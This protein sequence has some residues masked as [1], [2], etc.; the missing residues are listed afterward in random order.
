MQLCPLPRMREHRDP[1]SPGLQDQQMAVRAF[2]LWQEKHVSS[3]HE[4]HAVLQAFQNVDTGVTAQGVT[5]GLRRVAEHDPCP[6]PG[7]VT[8][9]VQED[10][11][12]QQ[13]GANVQQQ[14]LANRKP[15]RSPRVLNTVC[16]KLQAPWQPRWDHAD[17]RALS[18]GDVFHLC[19]RPRHDAV[20][21]HR[22]LG[23]RL[24]ICKNAGVLHHQDPGQVWSGGNPGRVH[25]RCNQDVAVLLHFEVRRV[26]Q[27]GVV[28]QAQQHPGLIQPVH[29]HSRDEKGPRVEHR[30]HAE[31][32]AVHGPV[33][34]E[35]GE[36]EAQPQA[37]GH[38]RMVVPRM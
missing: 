33:H 22:V 10:A 3:V 16:I 18:L 31:Q 15:K 24:R 6:G 8:Q 4:S 28:P 12:P 11:G 14:L 36:E 23:K 25:A 29:L 21:F 38:P 2:E 9:H 13:A 7:Q 27:H 34:H 17:A 37:C 26:E 19:G 20:I 1:S 32:P 35:I 30:R 5:G